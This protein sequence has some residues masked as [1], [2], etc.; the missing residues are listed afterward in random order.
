MG[1][2]QVDSK[3]AN[4]NRTTDLGAGRLERIRIVLINTT[5]PGNIGSAAR[6]MKVMGLS[7]LHLVSPKIWPSADATALASGAADLLHTA[8]VHDNLEQALEGCR[9]VLGTSARLRSL[10]MPQMDVR[11]AAGDTKEGATL[12]R[13]HMA[14]ALQRNVTVAD[15]EAL[16]PNIRA[17]LLQIGQQVVLPPPA[18]AVAQAAAGTAVPL[19][20]EVVSLETVRTP[21]G[22]VWV[23]GEV[24]N[25]GDVPAANV[26]VTVSLPVAGGEHTV[27]TWTAGALVPAG[28]RAPFAA[29]VAELPAVMGPRPRRSR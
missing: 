1:S 16:N 3:G 19:Q 22:S 26:Q 24:A 15:I 20:I 21:V 27:T 9:L 28:G 23:L 10:S 2:E 25:R 8:A 13:L 6:A 18:T 5:H 7:Q 4:D 17:E 29:L 11:A 12:G 14:I